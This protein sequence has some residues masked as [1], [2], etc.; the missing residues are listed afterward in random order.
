[1]KNWWRNR[2]EELGLDRRI[3]KMGF[4]EIG[5]NVTECNAL[6]QGR[7]NWPALT[8]MVMKTSDYIKCS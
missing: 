7:E 5:W 6:V 3:I 8:N 1:V 2:F 4:T